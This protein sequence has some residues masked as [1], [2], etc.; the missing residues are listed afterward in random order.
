[1]TPEQDF[2]GGVRLN[3]KYSEIESNVPIDDNT[4]VTPA[5]VLKLIELSP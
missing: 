5:S 4:F 1:M 3:V 2:P